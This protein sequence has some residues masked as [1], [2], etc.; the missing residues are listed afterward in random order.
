MGQ[1]EGTQVV[2]PTSQGHLTT[3]MLRAEIAPWSTWTAR[4][5]L[6]EYSLYMLGGAGILFDSN[7]R[8]GPGTGWRV[9]IGGHANHYTRDYSL[10]L[11]VE[12]QLSRMTFQRFQSTSPRV[13]L[14][15]GF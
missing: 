7:L 1:R 5:S 6:P 3:L 4:T 9:G 10:P 14:G 15:L 11:F 8:P 13:L 12:L 2:G